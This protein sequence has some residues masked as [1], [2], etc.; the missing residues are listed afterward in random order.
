VINFF[1]RNPVAVILICVAILSRLIVAFLPPVNLL[2]SIDERIMNDSTLLLFTNSTPTCLEWPATTLMIPLFIISFINMLFHTDFISSILHFDMIKI[3]DAINTHLYYYFNNVDLIR[4][5]RIL[6]AVIGL[7][8]YI[9]IFRFL[10]TEKKEF[11]YFFVFLYTVSPAF[12]IQSW[13]LHPDSIAVV[14]WVLFILYYIFCFDLTSNKSLVILAALFVLLAASKF[15]YV[16]FLPLLLLSF[17]FFN[18]KKHGWLFTIKQTIKF[19]IIS[20]VFLAALFP[21][22]WTDSITFAKSFFGN[23]FMKSSG[24]G[25]SLG[26]LLTGY[27]PSLITYPGLILSLIGL[28]LSF[29]KLGKSKTVFLI[30]TF[31]LFAYPIANASQ[32]YER[33]SLALLPMLLIW[34]AYGFVYISEKINNPVFLKTSIALIIVLSSVQSANSV[35]KNFSSYHEQN[36]FIAC[37]TWLNQNLQAD[38]KVAL[39]VTYEGYFY[40]NKNCLS[41]IIKRNSDSLLIATK[42]QTQI[43]PEYKNKP[44]NVH[45]VILEDLFLDEKKYLDQKFRVKYDFVSSH[46]V[47]EKVFDIYYYTEK[48]FTSLHCFKYNEVIS[49]TSVKYVLTENKKDSRFH[50]VEKF[51]A[52]KDTPYYLYL[53]EHSN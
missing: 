50:L 47:G 8:S 7:V 3:S 22:L 13:V 25:N 38:E 16:I 39:P 28:G 26:L 18:F 35:W 42:L 36:N 49:D 46:P 11:G 23:I 10:K 15:T 4:T 29:F 41:R 21:F 6:I 9:F 12:I 14:F 31:L 27:L 24:K 20:G 48:D 43:R 30:L 44:L 40:E 34:S 37:R 5:G 2:Y 51:D 32:T 52:F 1:R 45:A 17:I 53:K 33:Y 19:L